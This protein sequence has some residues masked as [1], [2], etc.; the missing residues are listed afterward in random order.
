M[1]V[2]DAVRGHTG[3]LIDADMLAPIISGCVGSIEASAFLQFR[4]TLEERPTMR[5]ILDAPQSAKVPKKHPDQTAV[6]SMVVANAESADANGDLM[7]LAEYLGRLSR[8]SVL[9][10][11]KKAMN[12]ATAAGDGVRTS[13]IAKLRGLVDS[14]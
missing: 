12:D 6:A 1:A 3:G 5:E 14:L 9:A 7:T 10:A 13:L 2:S 8:E 11:M 4:E